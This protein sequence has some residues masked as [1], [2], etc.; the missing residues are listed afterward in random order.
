MVTSQRVTNIETIDEGHISYTSDHLPIICKLKTEN[1]YSKQK[2]GLRGTKLNKLI[3]TDI[4]MK[5]KNH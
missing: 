1:V 2:H 4:K 3:L 5:Y